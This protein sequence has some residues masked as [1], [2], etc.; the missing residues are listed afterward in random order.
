[1]TGF[2]EPLVTW[3]KLTG[4]LHKNRITYALGKE[5]VTLTMAKKQDTGP[6][7]CSAINALGKASAVTTV[8]VWS[9]PKFVWKPPSSVTKLS[10]ESLSLSCSAS[11]DSM[12]L[13]SWK[14]TSGAWVEARMKVLNGTL[15]ISGLL[16]AD[17]GIYVCEA[18]SPHFVIEARTHVEVK[19]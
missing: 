4:S 9:A 14:R 15:K 12:P 1:M 16:T 8:V 6:Y 3:T 17:S 11:G 10:G 13:V 19:G 7:V 2:P 5:L 18:K